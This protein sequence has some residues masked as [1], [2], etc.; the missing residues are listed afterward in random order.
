MK[1][2]IGPPKYDDWMPEGQKLKTTWKKT[3]FCFQNCFDLLWVK[4]NVIKTKNQKNFWDHYEKNLS[5]ISQCVST[6]WSLSL[7]ALGVHE[8]D[9]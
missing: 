3:V 1:L 4:K 8:S 9:K 7:I 6:V 5:L 2:M